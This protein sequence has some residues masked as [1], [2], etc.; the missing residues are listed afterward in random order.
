MAKSPE[1]TA[2]L[3]ALTALYGEYTAHE[4]G[5]YEISYRFETPT[6]R[7]IVAS[8]IFKYPLRSVRTVQKS[9][10]PKR[11]TVIDA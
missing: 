8:D 4:S 6:E 3:A 11:G 7:I 1:L 5:D 2:K 10:I 9:D